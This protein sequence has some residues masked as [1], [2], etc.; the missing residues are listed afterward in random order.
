M[1]PDSKRRKI[2]ELFKISKD[3][4]SA[5]I[6]VDQNKSDLIGEKLNETVPIYFSGQ[7]RPV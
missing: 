1:E 4:D 6:D 7:K 5:S 3:S 2:I